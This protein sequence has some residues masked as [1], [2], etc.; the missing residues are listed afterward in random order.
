MR[1]VI[2]PGSTQVLQQ[3]RMKFPNILIFLILTLAWINTAAA[4]DSTVNAP[5][6]TT[7]FTKVGQ[8]GDLA[9]LAAPFRKSPVNHARDFE[10]LEGSDIGLTEGFR[11]GIRDY[12]DPFWIG[13]G[14]ASG[15]YNRDGWQD[16]I[17]GSNNGFYLYKNTGGK[18][19]LQG[20]PNTAITRLQVYAVALVDLN[21][22]GWADIFFTTFDDGNFLILNRQGQFDYNNLISVPNQNAVLTLSPAFA[23][24]DLNGQLDIVNGNIALG[25]VT[26]MHHM[27]QR[28]NN[29]IV[30]NDFPNFR[31]VPMETVS[32]ETMASL[33]SDFNNDGIADIYFGNDFII[34]DKILLGTGKGYKPVTGN[35]FIP[36]TPFFSMGADT[37]DIDNDLA[38]DFL[39]TGTMYTAP[40]VGKQAIDGKSVQEY[41]RFRGDVET[42]QS[43]KDARYRKDCL[44]I[45]RAR[46]IDQL[47]TTQN[48]SLEGC[49]QSTDKIQRDICLTQQMWTLIT[50]DNHADR[51]A[52]KFGQ[53]KKLEQVCNILQLKDRRYDKRDLYGA[54]PQDDRNM[55]YRFDADSQS[56]RAV[57]E[58]K[59]PGG[60]TWNGRIADLDSDG[61][62]DIITADGTVRKSDYGWNVLMH[63]ID[64]KRF[65]QIQFSAGVTDDFGLYSFSLI[66]M[67]ND[68][69]LDIIGNSAEGAVQVYRNH[70]GKN[71]HRIAVSL[72]DQRGNYDS[73]GAKVS[74]HYHQGKK[75]QIRE[76][77][78]GG[79][80]LSFDAPVAYFGLGDDGQVDEI[81]VHWADKTHSLI[82]G[83]FRSHYHYQIT[84]QQPQK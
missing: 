56:L 29:S 63:N 77:K 76:I 18:F 7:T 43:V 17:L 1:L 68:G 13:R 14:T 55:L 69:D 31:D 12:T 65:E 41:S 4:I 53:D 11:Y 72:Q 20:Q 75:A 26:G 38:L 23:D 61:W 32:G 79:G 52:E 84:R 5:A 25:V 62:Q 34:P 48:S 28:R 21:N 9:I 59:H 83:P 15:D 22:D 30:F 8:Q 57:T 67:D 50:K 45:R 64:G 27:Q 37:G 33:V 66:D 71:N 78:A 51:C 54:I 10:K 35:K 3:S 40:F 19:E 80:Y 46:Y 44:A 47:D 36:F 82:T 49:V 16:I 2:Q 39:I 73:I 58:F 70:S 60:W 42:C 6:V 24:L 81:R 74:I